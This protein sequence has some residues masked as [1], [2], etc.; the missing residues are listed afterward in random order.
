MI[1]LTI[2]FLL[3]TLVINAG[4]WAF[5]QEAVADVW[6]DEQRCLTV[7]DGHT[8]TTPDATQTDT[9]NIPCNHWC[10]AIVHLVGLHR[11]IAHVTS[12]FTS[13]YPAQQ[14]LSNLFSF[15]DCLYRP[16]RFSS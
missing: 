3:I 10:H 15:P 7:D 16:P 8:S 14:S 11:Q 9:P 13:E 12:E 2:N 4:G 6:F 5:N 1:S